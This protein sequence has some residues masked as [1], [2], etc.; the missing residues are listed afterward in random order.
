M[1]IRHLLSALFGLMALISLGFIAWETFGL[2]T[3]FRK[4]DWLV[5]ANRLAD[6]VIE[7]NSIQARERGLTNILISRPESITDETRAQML[8]LRATGD[9]LYRQVLAMAREIAG[10]D[11]SHPLN[12]SLQ[13][14]AKHRV[15][16]EY[17]R[18]IADRILDNKDIPT[19]REPWF[20]TMDAFIT[21]LIQV[22]RDAFAPVD[23]FGR[24][25][26]YNLLSKEVVFSA[27]EHAGQERAIIG[28]A[29]AEARPLSMEEV[30]RLRYSRATVEN[31]LEQL[32]LE[33]EGTNRGPELKEAMDRLNEEFL[34]R[35]QRLRIAVYTA[36]EQLT[37]YPVDAST[38]FVEAT[39]GIDSI[40]A[41][42]AAVSRRAEQ[43]TSAVHRQ[44]IR[45]GVLLVAVIA[46]VLAAMFATVVLVRK[47]IFLPLQT[48]TTASER[49]AAGD[50]QRP[51]AVTGN[52]EFSV[53]A[54][55]FEGM[56]NSLLS[57]IMER[58][59][60]QETLRLSEERFALVARGTRDGLWD[61]CLQ[62]GKIYFSPRWKV[63]LGYG[64]AE[65]A[66]DFAALQ[67]LI[68]PDDLGV[69]LEAWL[70]CLEGKTDAFS[71]EYR[72]RDNQG[73]YRWIQCRGLSVRKGE[74]EPVRM[75]GSHTDI[76]KR[77][78]AQEQLQ[79]TSAH[80][81]YLVDNSPAIIYGAVPSGDFRL[82]F[83]SE[84][85]TRLLGYTP[86]EMLANPNFWHDHIHPDDTIP[87]FSK[88]FTLFS[89]VEQT[90]DYRFQHKDGHY[91]WIHDTMRVI[92]DAKGKTL[93]V[94]G[95]LLDISELKG[96][97]NRLQAE[98]AEQQVLIQKLQEAQEQLL[99]SEKL[100]S[101]GQLAAGV[102]HEINNPVGYIYSNLNTLQGHTG[103]LIEML[104][105]YEVSRA[106]AS[107]DSAISDPISTK[108]EEL[109][110]DYLKEDVLDL[111]RESQ[112]GI[113][114]VKQIVQ[115][116][117]DFSHVDQAEWQWADLHHG[118]DS[119]LN[120]VNNELKYKAEVVK[121]YGELPLVECLASQLNQVF[122]NLL[123]NSAHAI[124][125]RGTITVRTGTVS[126]E[127]EWVWVEI[128]D[129]GKGI[130]AEDLKRIFDPFFTT[131]PVGSGT[132]LGLSLSYGIVN[133][134]GGRID[135]DS[136]PG[137]GTTFRVW[138]PVHQAET[139]MEAAG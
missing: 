53:L 26:H 138:L 58:E 136:E 94:L 10:R 40:L 90:H 88:L 87:V 39:R 103:K 110:L 134:H 50:L 69:A 73:G 92:R 112:E 49:I 117:K 126:K 5:Q 75:A 120:I 77:K 29:I 98:K 83:V 60:A 36:S 54:R 25:Y 44:V 12:G 74:G 139:P 31:K 93:E 91:C 51:L 72:L 81:Q 97:E 42:A 22:R 96:M 47:R 100:A 46:V 119:T 11:P 19:I 14:L 2:T 67:D 124:E 107:I 79:K 64:E 59:R 1:K 125:Q 76:S 27:S 135:V 28:A 122:M 129:T 80:L 34:G 114:R 121:E 8:E 130:E 63:M 65:I 101:I 66:N 3:T 32:V 68:H 61:W 105:L 95:S 57:D 70:D 108:K 111:V 116:L 45:G 20:D 16:V 89:D 24:A 48:L 132:G 15:A 78:Q 23:E 13:T 35:Y 84:N 6:H 109:D 52:D 62:T 9:N 43:N 102:A 115:D 30:H 128:A 86:A 41:V 55:S 38:W 37:A 4:A 123:V 82:T 113:V 21:T 7:A 99:Q 33:I 127:D 17:A 71:V 131:K 18:G 106:S 118:L 85:V 56:R 133:K 104:N 137:Q